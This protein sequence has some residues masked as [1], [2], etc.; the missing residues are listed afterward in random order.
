MQFHRFRGLEIWKIQR[1]FLDVR[2]FVDL[3]LS[4]FDCL[5]K[6]LETCW[7]NCS[8]GTSIGSFFTLP[9]LKNNFVTFL[10][11]CRTFSRWFLAQ[12]AWIH[13]IISL[14][15]RAFFSKLHGLGRVTTGGKE[16]VHFMSQTFRSSMED[17]S[18]EQ[19]ENL[20]VDSW[21]K[22]FWRMFGEINA[23]EMRESM[24][25]YWVKRSYFF[26]QKTMICWYL[27]IG[28]DFV[29]WTN[30]LGCKGLFS[31]GPLVFIG[32]VYLMGMQC[33]CPIAITVYTWFRD[34]RFFEVDLFF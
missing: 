24:A 33:G 26:L 13:G 18:V 4:S 2:M 29:S 12:T 10:I 17:Y 27:S 6:K 7:F 20:I 28:S 30:M 3:Y 25:D 15:S 8:G 34:S 11:R 21:V 9:N 31:Y 1:P 5:T 22:C 23:W 14:E 32:S 16:K 19:R